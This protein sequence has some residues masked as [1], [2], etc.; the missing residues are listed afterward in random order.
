[1]RIFRAISPH[2]APLS[3]RVQTPIPLSGLDPYI[4]SVNSEDTGTTKK[5]H[6]KQ[7]ITDSTLQRLIE[8]S[9]YGF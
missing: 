3:G 1:M 2:P 7:K 6:A 8:F 9:Q 4:K 5:Q